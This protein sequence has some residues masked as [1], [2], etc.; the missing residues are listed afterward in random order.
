V[1]GPPSL[2]TPNTARA[3]AYSRIAMR[4]RIPAGL[5]VVALLFTSAAAEGSAPARTATAKGC[6]S[7]QLV[8]KLGSSEAALGHIGQVV[9]FL[10]VS[11]S[12]CTLEGYPDLQM[13]DAAGGSVHTR[14]RHGIAY[15]VPPVPRRLVVVKPGAR[16]SFD[17]GYDDS[18]GYEREQCPTSARVEVTPPHAS[19][20][21]TVP[22]RIQPYG[23]GSV[24]HLRCGEITVSAIFAGR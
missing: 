16:A 6:S 13:L 14:L 2:Q 22:W 19:T 7:P 17:V 21:I 10:N 15:T 4:S 11:P 12:T 1:A 8:V 23:G 24:T 18:T 9:H 20:P 3:P 5:A